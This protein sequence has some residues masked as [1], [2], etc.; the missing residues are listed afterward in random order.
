MLQN[1]G[2]WVRSMLRNVHELA[3]SNNN[4][5]LLVGHLI[6]HNA[7]NRNHKSKWYM[8]ES[9][10]P[11]KTYPPFLSGT[12]YLMSRYTNYMIQQT[13]RQIQLDQSHN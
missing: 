8:A 3:I 1:M 6:C 2:H 4:T 11:G 12:G 9:I 7:P 5:D 13:F 10:Y